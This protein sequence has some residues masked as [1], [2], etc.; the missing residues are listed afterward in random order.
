MQSEGWIHRQGQ[1]DSYAGVTLCGVVNPAAGQSKH[2]TGQRGYVDLCDKV[3]LRQCS[4]KAL[5]ARTLSITSDNTHNVKSA[6]KMQ[7][8]MGLDDLRKL[9]AKWVAQQYVS[10]L[11]DQQQHAGNSDAEAN[12][13]TYV[14]KLRCIDSPEIVVLTSPLAWRGTSVQQEREDQ[15]HEHKTRHKMFDHGCMASYWCCAERSL[16]RSWRM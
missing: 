13:P 5:I 3:T 7:K 4:C 12:G 15:D 11:K 1:K 14:V 16:A 10:R 2:D 8:G 6:R 9:C